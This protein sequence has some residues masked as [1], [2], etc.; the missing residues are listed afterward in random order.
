MRPEGRR[1]LAIPSHLVGGGAGL[2]VGQLPA[3]LVLHMEVTVAAGQ[4]QTRLRVL[5]E[6][7]SVGVL[8]RECLCLV[9][10]GVC[11]R[12]RVSCRVGSG[13]VGSCRVG[14]R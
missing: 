3:G 2:N 14:W 12:A 9:R 5:C 10:E 13:R 1:R 4:T 6:C 11:V 7:A 8:A